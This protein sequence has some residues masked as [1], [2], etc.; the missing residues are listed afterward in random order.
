MNNFSN[1]SVNHIEF[2][3]LIVFGEYLPSQS[4]IENMLKL[5]NNKPQKIKFRD[6]SNHFNISCSF[7]RSRELPF[8]I[9]NEN[10]YLKWFNNLG[11]FDSISLAQADAIY[12]KMLERKCVLTGHEFHRVAQSEYILEWYQFLFGNHGNGNEKQT[13]EMANLW[14]KGSQDKNYSKFTEFQ[15]KEQNRY[16]DFYDKYEDYY[17]AEKYY[18]RFMATDDNPILLNGKSMILQASANIIGIRRKIAKIIENHRVYGQQKQMFWCD[19]CR[20]HSRVNPGKLPKICCSCKNLKD[21]EHKQS[22]QRGGW[23]YHHT[24]VCNGHCVSDRKKLDI[25]CI[26]KSCYGLNDCQIRV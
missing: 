12:F 9:F 25:F 10:S 2:M 21:I 8:D 5:H 1:I 17:R 14:L 20:K 3:Q 11:N 6:F 23:E 18:S 7:Y 19:K 22:R 24:G 4:M 13:R 16:G 15:E 26:C